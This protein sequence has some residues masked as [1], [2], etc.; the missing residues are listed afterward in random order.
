MWLFRAR[1]NEWAR[2][3]GPRQLGPFVRAGGEQVVGLWGLIPHFA[4]SAVSPYATNNARWESIKTKP[5]FRSAW[6]KGQR[7]II[8][9]D[10]FTEPC[11]ETGKSV[12]VSFRRADGKPWALAGLWNTWTDQDT[13]EVVES[14]TMITQNADDH[15]I[16]RRMHK[17]DP[18][19][20]PED[21]DKRSVVPIEL[22]DVDTW[23]HGREG[24]A[25]ALVRLPGVE[26]FDPACIPS[27]PASLF[28]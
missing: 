6:A 4:A 12:L 24:E 25:S 8:P 26:V 19:L 16:M 17:P 9:A 15:P 28:G 5:T 13:G 18:K 22:A 2:S 20:G 23:L 7:C 1:G 10:S 3:I 27:P 11:W 14:Y 21:Q